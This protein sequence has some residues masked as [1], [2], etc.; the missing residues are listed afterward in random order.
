MS[1]LPV[2]TLEDLDSLPLADII[3]GYTSA[4]IG[5]PEPGENRGRAY[6]HGWRNRMLDNGVIPPDA[7]SEG[8]AALYV[9]RERN[10]KNT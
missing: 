8:L 1:F 3:D 5:D 10:K 4:K 2:R 9:A 7:A 6:W